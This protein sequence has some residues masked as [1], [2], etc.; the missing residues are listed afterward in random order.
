MHSVSCLGT[1]STLDNL[2]HTLLFHSGS[3]GI[4]SLSNRTCVICLLLSLIS[5]FTWRILSCKDM[6]ALT[7]RKL[8]CD[9]SLVISVSRV[10]ALNFPKVTCIPTIGWKKITMFLMWVLGAIHPNSRNVSV[11]PRPATWSFSLPSN[12]YHA[13]VGEYLDVAQVHT[14]A[15]CCEG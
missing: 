3:P 2:W 12:K 8:T 5:A 4:P 13:G 9:S 6:V 1:T 14:V 10:P 7:R 11:R 15:Q